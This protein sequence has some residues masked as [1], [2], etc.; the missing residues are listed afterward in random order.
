MKKVLDKFLLKNKLVYIL[1]GNGHIGYDVTKTISLL[2][3][4]CLVLDI[5]N[6]KIKKIKNNQLKFEKFDCSKLDSIKFFVSSDATKRLIR[7][8]LRL[9]KYGCTS[10]NTFRT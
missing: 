2:G 8:L 7:K 1:G 6:N 10:C 4:K 3:A 9:S 5:T